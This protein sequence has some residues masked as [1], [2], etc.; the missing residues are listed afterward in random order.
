MALACPSGSCR[1]GPNT[2]KAA[3]ATNTARVRPNSQRPPPG[4]A[5]VSSMITANGMI[6]VTRMAKAGIGTPS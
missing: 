3:M 4:S 5:P 2:P 6:E 1:P